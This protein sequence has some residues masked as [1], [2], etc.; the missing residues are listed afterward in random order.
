MER[1]M[2]LNS[3]VLQEPSTTELVWKRGQIVYL[4]LV[5]M[6]VMSGDLSDQIGFVVLDISAEKVP[7]VQLL[8]LETK[9]TS[10]LKD[11]IALKVWNFGSIDIS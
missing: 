8:T 10:A 4:A 1:D 6:S 11:I 2:L 9:Q 3:S 5:A 7:T